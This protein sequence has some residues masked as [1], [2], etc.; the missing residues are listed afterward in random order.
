VLVTRARRDSR[1]PTVASRLWLR[2][3][4]MTGGL[5]RDHRLERWAAAIDRPSDVRPADRPAPAPPAAARPKKISVTRVDRLKADPFAFYAS[6]MLKLN[7]LDPVDAEQSAQW[8]GSA[9]HETFQAWFEEDR[10]DPDALLDRARAL[11]AGDAIHPMLRALW[12]PRLLAAIDWLAGQ[13][14]DNRAAGRTPLAAEADGKTEIGGITLYGRADRI[15]RLADSRLAIVDYK[16]G[17]PPKQKAIDAG[18]A[19][20]LGLLGLIACDGGFEGIEGL[21][22]AHE[23]WSLAKDPKSGDFGFCQR[24]DAKAG[25]EAM[26]ADAERNFLALAADYLAGDKPFTA[27]L[28]PAYAPYGDYDQLMRLDEWYGRAD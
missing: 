25:A 17:K 8:K 6:Q 21:P 28:H 4:A 19:L 7:R 23:Y 24:A 11:L 5:V 10:C 13:E 3:Q 18:F 1:A 20:Q 22:G 9:V 2:L 26:L 27:K 12:Q 14:R 15:D 16:T